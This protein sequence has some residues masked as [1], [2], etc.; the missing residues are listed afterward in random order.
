MQKARQGGRSGKALPAW[1]PGRREMTPT[2]RP[3]RRPRPA[4]SSMTAFAAAVKLGGDTRGANPQL[5]ERSPVLTDSGTR[6]S[7]SHDPRTPGSSAPGC[8]PTASPA[9]LRLI[10]QEKQPVSQVHQTWG[11]GYRASQGHKLARGTGALAIASRVGCSKHLPSNHYD[12]LHAWGEPAAP[13]PSEQTSAL[14]R[15]GPG[16][17]PSKSP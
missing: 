11:K 5:R 4:T 3:T 2:V 15:A 9:Q 10:N 1:G 6:L 16:T 7:R 14:G 13:S 17:P 8:P 12:K